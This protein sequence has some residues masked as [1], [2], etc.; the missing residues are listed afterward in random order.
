M[1][2]FLSVQMPRAIG[3]QDVCAMPSIS[4]PSA[5]FFSQ[6]RMPEDAFA[7]ID[8]DVVVSEREQRCGDV[9]A[10]R[11]ELRIE[12][13]RDFA[14][15]VDDL[16]LAELLRLVEMRLEME[17][18]VVRDGDLHAAHRLIAASTMR[19]ISSAMRDSG[20]ARQDHEIA[21]DRMN[22]GQWIH[23][24]EVR[25]AVAIAADVDA[26]DV[27]KSERA[28]DLQRDL[29]DVRRV[30][31][32]VVD[33]VEVVALHVE[34]VDEVFVVAARERPASRRGLRRR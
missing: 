31:E 9:V 18:V 21:V 32:T 3:S 19:P 23:L 4:R 8:D 28:P 34:R 17:V 2:S 1:T 26:R 30:D 7:E 6:S 5:K 25:D 29:G 24:D 13:L 22:A 15:G 10:Y 33:A 27:A 14:R 20:E 16:R 11:D 12:Q